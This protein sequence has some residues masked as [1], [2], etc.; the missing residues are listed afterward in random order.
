MQRITVVLADDNLIVRE[1]V[2]PL[3]GAD[4]EIEVVGVAGDCDELVRECAGKAPTVLVTDI[5]MSLNFQ[6][7]DIQ[8]RSRRAAL[9]RAGHVLRAA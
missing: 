4:R 1:G 7:D 3:P 5:R 6:D 8:A 9:L 2:R